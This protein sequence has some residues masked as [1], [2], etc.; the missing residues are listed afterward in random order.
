ML[1]AI[2]IVLINLGFVLTWGIRYK[3]QWPRAVALENYTP[4]NVYLPMEAILTVLLVISCAF[5][6]AYTYQR[7]RT[8]L[9]E[10]FSLLNGTT[11]GILGLMAITY[12]L[13]DLSF[14]PNGIYTLEIGSISLGG[15]V[16][17]LIKQ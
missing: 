14:L 3:L 1:I 17:K 16:F 9:D 5:Q 15:A 12:A 7:G 11:T 4:L 8:W 2:D 10:A 13:P 6:K